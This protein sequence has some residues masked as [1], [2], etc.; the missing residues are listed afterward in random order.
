MLLTDLIMNDL[1]IS[2]SFKKDWLHII[3]YNIYIRHGTQTQ[4]GKW[5]DVD[6]LIEIYNKYD[7]LLN[8][9]KY[10]TD[11]DY[12]WITDFRKQVN[13]WKLDCSKLIDF[14]LANYINNK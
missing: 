4:T 9:A 6:N 3:N 1:K 8:N 7:Y 5:L 13:E 12:P 11:I 2:S 10:Y 14:Y